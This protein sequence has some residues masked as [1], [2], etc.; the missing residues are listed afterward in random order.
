L[1]QILLEDAMRDIFQNRAILNGSEES[2]VIT[3]LFIPIPSQDAVMLL[4]PLLPF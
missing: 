2:L 3:D 4:S 1:E